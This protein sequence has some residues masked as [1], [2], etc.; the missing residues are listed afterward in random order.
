M[1]FPPE[2]AMVYDQ[3]LPTDTWPTVCGVWPPDGEFSRPATM[4]PLEWKYSSISGLV[5]EPPVPRW[6][7][8]TH[9][10]DVTDTTRSVALS[11]WLPL[12]DQ[13]AGLPSLFIS[14]SSERAKFEFGVVTPFS[15]AQNVMAPS[16]VSV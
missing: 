11:L 10:F 7:W 2:T 3:V 15:G 6:I 4:S 12:S 14:R 16:R 5:D 9:T 8:P 13:F 1:V